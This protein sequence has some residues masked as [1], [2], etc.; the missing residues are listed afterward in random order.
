[1]LLFLKTFIDFPHANIET[2]TF[3]EL[4]LIFANLLFEQLRFS[5]RVWLKE[6]KKQLTSIKP[7]SQSNAF[8][9]EF[10]FAKVE[11][12]LICLLKSLQNSN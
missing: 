4:A 1:M 8:Y 6:G 7:R 2:M 12:L 11:L 5:E 10:I 9:L 3:H